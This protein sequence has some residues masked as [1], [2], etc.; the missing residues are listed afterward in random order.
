MTYPNARTE[1]TPARLSRRNMV[2][3]TA[4]A[5]P[6][7]MAVGAAPAMAASLPV[8]MT[9][10]RT[11]KDFRFGFAAADPVTGDVVTITNITG[12]PALAEQ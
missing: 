6:L 12:A 1:Y 10:S 3:G 2:V 11:G 9:F 8:T 7:V 5:A 4:W